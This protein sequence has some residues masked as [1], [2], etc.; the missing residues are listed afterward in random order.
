MPPQRI[1]DIVA[2]KRAVTADTELRLCPYSGLSDGW[3]LRGQASQDIDVA[4]EAMREELA[5]IP[6]CALLTAAT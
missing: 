4:R 3:C 1:G 2:Y 5:R 6:R